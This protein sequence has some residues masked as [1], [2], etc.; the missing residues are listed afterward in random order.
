MIN[1]I[2]L[3]LVLAVIGYS[4]YKIYDH[5][6]DEDKTKLVA[7]SVI[8][9]ISAVMAYFVARYRFGMFKSH[10][11]QVFEKSIERFLKMD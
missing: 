3:V 10:E 1:L 2:L 6:E 7:Y 4:S 5:R 9:A 8:L 11:E